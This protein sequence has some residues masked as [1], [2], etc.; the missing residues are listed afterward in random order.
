[1]T[2][3]IVTYAGDAGTPFD[4]RHWIDVHLP[5]VRAGWGPHGLLSA[6]GFFPDGDGAGVIAVAL[7]VF[8]DAAAME[9]ALA[10]DAT[11]GIMADVARVTS[12]APQRRLAA[13]I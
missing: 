6:G 1:M 9:A 11:S 10:S 2:T 12:V 4:R 3:M 13:I 5:L 8:R 7:C